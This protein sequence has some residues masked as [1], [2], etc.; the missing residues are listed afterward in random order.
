MADR[1]LNLWTVY[2]HPLDFPSGFIARRWVVGPGAE[3]TPTGECVTASTL[4]AVRAKL[5]SG[6]YRLD[7]V[8][9]DDPCI[10]ETWV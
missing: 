9:D 10:V 8:S 2:G 1:H 5:P 7:R 6:L 3:P 4:E